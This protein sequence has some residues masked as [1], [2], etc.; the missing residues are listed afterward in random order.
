MDVASDQ[1]HN[2]NIDAVYVENHPA[3][4]YILCSVLVPPTHRFTSKAPGNVVK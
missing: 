3:F 1:K 4:D 2:Q